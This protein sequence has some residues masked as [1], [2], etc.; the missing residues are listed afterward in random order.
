MV[1]LMIYIYRYPNSIGCNIQLFVDE[2]KRVAK[3]LSGS[4]KWIKG[5]EGDSFYVIFCFDTSGKVLRTES[6][7]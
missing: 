2:V 7:E 6:P 4:N 3:E 1:S 5:F